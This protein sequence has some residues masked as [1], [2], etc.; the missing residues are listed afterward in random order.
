M[1]SRLKASCQLQAYHQH[2]IEACGSLAR[3]K[4][5]CFSD[6]N[7]KS[8]VVDCCY[9]ISPSSSPELAFPCL[10][11]EHPRKSNAVACYLAIAKAAEDS[12]LTLDCCVPGLVSAFEAAV[13]STCRD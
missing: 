7:D 1:A 5:C 8:P 13:P 10:L 9:P 6:A 2:A 12:L 4:L 11:R 3:E